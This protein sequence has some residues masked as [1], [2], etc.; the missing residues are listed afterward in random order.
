MRVL[1]LGATAAFILVVLALRALL[2]YVV[3][4]F[5]FPV[6]TRQ[7]DPRGRPLNAPAGILMETARARRI[8]ILFHGNG[9]LANEVEVGHGVVGDMNVLLVEY[10]GYGMD[11]TGRPTPASVRARADVAFEWARANSHGMPIWV[12]GHS[13][14]SGPACYLAEKYGAAV[15]RLILVSAF[16][17]ILD[18]IRAVVPWRLAHASVCALLWRADLFDNVAALRDYRNPVYIVHGALD[19]TMPVAMVA[20]LEEASGN[21]HVNV[22]PFARHNFREWQ[23]HVWGFAFN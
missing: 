7:E 17:S 22:V 19:A 8:L 15:D 6:W 11:T 9:E 18:V 1:L 10:P 4:R 16:T 14:G 20:R 13:I 12:M 21:P 23:K 2:V 3:T 5:L